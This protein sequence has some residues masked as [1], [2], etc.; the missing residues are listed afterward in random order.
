MKKLKHKYLVA[1]LLFFFLAC[2][3]ENVTNTD[4]INGYSLTNKEIESHLSL[5]KLDNINSQIILGKYYSYANYNP[6]KSI[7]WFEKAAKLGSI[8]GMTIFSSLVIKKWPEK[9]DQAYLYL[10]MLASLGDRNSKVN[11]AKLCSKYKKCSY[12]VIHELIE[13]SVYDPEEYAYNLLC[14]LNKNEI[15][16][17]QYES[18]AI[19]SVIHFHKELI[20][21]KTLCWKE[22]ESHGFFKKL[23]NLANILLVDSI[24]EHL[25]NLKLDK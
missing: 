20:T 24:E 11:L 17:S 7:Y 22:L 21:T 2:S 6:E 3:K 15:N 8:K 13:L 9:M 5:A 25:Q 19:L 23:N 16:L 10:K 4:A 14:Y 18:S 1:F 12:S